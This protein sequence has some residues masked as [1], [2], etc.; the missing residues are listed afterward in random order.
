[1]PLAFAVSGAAF[2]IHEANRWFYARSAFVHHVCGWLL[3]G[4][5]LFP[6]GAAFK[7][8][9]LVFNV[10]VAGVFLAASVALYAS[11]DLAPVFGHLDRSAGVPHR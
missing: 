3:L 2:L 5:A 7:P 4:G 10:G 1:M 8:R 6:L 11:R 9:S